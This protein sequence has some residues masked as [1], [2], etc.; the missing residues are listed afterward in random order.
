MKNVFSTNLEGESFQPCFIKNRKIY[1]NEEKYESENII[2][3]LIVMGSINLHLSQFPPHVPTAGIRS[4][5]TQLGRQKVPECLQ[6]R[7]HGSNLI[8]GHL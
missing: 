1:M 4:A 2:L 8:C 3:M 5:M 7:R 6:S